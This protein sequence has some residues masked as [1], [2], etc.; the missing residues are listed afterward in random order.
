MD[1]SCDAAVIRSEG[2]SSS[3]SGIIS[4]SAATG[5]RMDAKWRGRARPAS[6]I[7]L[8]VRTERRRFGAITGRNIGAPSAEGKPAPPLGLVAVE[9]CAPFTRIRPS[10]V[11]TAPPATG[12]SASLSSR[13]MDATITTESS[14]AGMAAGG[15]TTTNDEDD[16]LTTGNSAKFTAT[17]DWWPPRLPPVPPVKKK[18]FVEN[19]VTGVSC[20]VDGLES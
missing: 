4:S 18:E 10:C 9:P 11:A 19:G 2:S 15:G 5:R 14:K 16:G 1:T 3:S 12:V 13:R 8:R 6:S 7:A 17:V 20:R